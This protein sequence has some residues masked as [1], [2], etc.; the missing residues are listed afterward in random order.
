MDWN[1]LILNFIDVCFLWINVYWALESYEEK[2]LKWM[3]THLTVAI[4]LTISIGG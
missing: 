4:L 2:K 3:A 1:W